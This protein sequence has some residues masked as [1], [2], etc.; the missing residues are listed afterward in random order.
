MGVAMEGGVCNSE[1]CPK[2]GLAL[3]PCECTLGKHCRPEDK[4]ITKEER[5]ADPAESDAEELRSGE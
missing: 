5:D 4:A 2:H 1:T 3:S